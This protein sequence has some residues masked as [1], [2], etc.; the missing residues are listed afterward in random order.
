MTNATFRERS[1][2]DEVIYT[3]NVEQALLIAWRESQS[4]LSSAC[5]DPIKW[6]VNMIVQL[7]VRHCFVVLF[8]AVKSV[9]YHLSSLSI[10]DSRLNSP[11]WLEQ[12]CEI[13]L[14]E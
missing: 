4:E 9:V 10:D 8:Y 3:N 2:S 7:Y 13:V 12:K 14:R 6:P 1:Y 5:D 11:V